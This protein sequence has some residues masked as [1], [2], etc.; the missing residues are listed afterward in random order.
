MGT[1]WRRPIGCLKLQVIFRKRATKFRALLRKMTHKDE[2][3]YGS[4]P[5]ISYN[6]G[7]N[8]SRV[9]SRVVGHHPLRGEMVFENFLCRRRKRNAEILQALLRPGFSTIS[10]AG[11]AC[12]ELRS[13]LMFKKLLSRQ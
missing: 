2:A 12:G 7:A 6:A 11:M 8:F 1:G 3:S 13:D 10:F 4:P 5:C 9:G